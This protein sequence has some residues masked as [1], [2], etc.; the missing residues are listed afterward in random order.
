MKRFAFLAVI[1]ASV[2][3][4]GCSSNDT[5][6]AGLVVAAPQAAVACPS[7]CQPAPTAYSA[8]PMIVENQGVYA[9]AAP[10]GV[11]YRVGFDERARATIS[12]PGEVASCVTD[13]AAEGLLLVGKTLRCIT[14]KLWPTPVP[15]QRLVYT[16]LNAD[17]CAT[18]NSIPYTAPRASPPCGPRTAPV[19]PSTARSNPCE[20]PVEPPPQSVAVAKGGT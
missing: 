14:S 16:N 17:P 12:M 19:P 7:G 10:I 6:R 20:P 1:V 11:E 2:V 9:L 15:T 5:T 3:F 8:G 4:A 13:G 18:R